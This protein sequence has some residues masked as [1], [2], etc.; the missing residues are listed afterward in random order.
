VLI[1]SKSIVVVVVDE[2]AAYT[3]AYEYNF[4]FFEDK[5]NRKKLWT[6]TIQFAAGQ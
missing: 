1:L 5:N 6:Q 2:M 4:C 3:K